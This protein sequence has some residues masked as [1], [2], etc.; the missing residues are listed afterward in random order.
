MRVVRSEVVAD[1]IYTANLT[2]EIGG[3]ILVMEDIK[4]VS[5]DVAP[6]DIMSGDLNHETTLVVKGVAKW[7]KPEGYL[8][9][10][11]RNEQNDEG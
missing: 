5:I 3:N 4:S 10:L 6:L 2:M 8:N 1:G 11:E 7:F 9:Y